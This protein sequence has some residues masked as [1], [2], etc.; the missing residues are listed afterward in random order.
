MT[1]PLKPVTNKDIA[2]LLDRIADLLDAKHENPFRVRSYRTAA[3]SVSSVRQSLANLVREEG[4]EGL[5]GLKGVGEKLAGLIQEYVEKGTVEL[6]RDLEKEVPEDKLKAVEKKKSEHNFPEPIEI[7]VATIL[8]VDD[9]Y[10]K[11][12]AAGKLK[13]IAPRLLNPEKKAWLPL[14]AREY[15]GYTFTVMFS[16][17]A[18]AHKLGKTNDW[19]VVYYEKGKGENQC[20]V[21]T[22]TRGGLKGKRVIRGREAECEEYHAG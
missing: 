1:M 15:K 5:S 14:M 17:T 7:P 4:V 19:V 10:R 18:T 22:E 3:A 12:A 6:L 2:A 21:V 13:M 8:E 11:Q 16:N 9:E 20:T